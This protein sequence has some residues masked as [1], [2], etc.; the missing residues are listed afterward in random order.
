MTRH[1]WVLVHRYAGLYMAFFLT[2]AGLTGM[3]LAFYHEL[4]DWLNPP[5]NAV[6]VR[7]NQAMLEPFALHQRVLALEPK[8]T[9]DSV[10]LNPEPGEI[11]IAFLT[12]RID[13]AR[14]EAYPLKEKSVWLDPYTGDRLQAIERP[15]G[16]WPLT[17]QN[18]LPFIYALHY[19]LALNEVGVWLFGIAGLIWTVDC[20]VA[21]YLTLPNSS[22]KVGCAEQSEAH[23]SR[24]MRLVPRHIL[25][26]DRTL[27][28]GSRQRGF[29]SRWAVAWKIKWPASALRL[30]FDLH[31]AG[32]IWTWPMLFVFAWSAVF[33]NLPGVYYPVMNGLFAMPDLREYPHV[34]ELA[35]QRPE[36]AIA[37]H[38]AY[39]IG[40]RLMA[41]QARREG[42]QITGEDSLTYDPKKGVY[43]YVV[44]S[45]RDL[46]P[47]HTCL[48]FDAQSGEF[49]E[50]Y[51]P[52]GQ[53]V[54]TTVTNWLFS[55]HMARI[56]G[57]PF[58]IFVCGM[59][60]V[61]AML[62]V[63]GVYIWL[64]KRRAASLNRGKA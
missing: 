45:D 57:L 63:T 61:V 55:L 32:G 22:R 62:S 36:P 14:G 50:L 52:S 3:M 53:N 47:G 64:K 16:F 34:P 48:W 18:L 41:E 11:Y 7:Q 31:R 4:D 29:W 10:K 39:P 42:F 13:P 20:F 43:L 33:F 27:E 8:A 30:N 23:R 60:L 54:G 1:V 12:P 19:S 26:F 58:K 25:R 9:V 24:L 21:F 40:R 6:P 44:N 2:V 46:E 56:W 51:L 38:Q 35:K 17:R 37:W 28:N 59:G 49:R 5:Q 15:E